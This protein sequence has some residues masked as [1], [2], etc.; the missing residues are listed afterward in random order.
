MSVNETLFASVVLELMR[1]AA[2]EL[3]EPVL[4]KLHEKYDMETNQTARKQFEAIFNNCKIACDRQVPVCQDNG[5]TQIFIDFGQQCKMEGNLEEAAK[6]AIAIATKAIPLR[7]NAIHPLSKKNP[8]TNV[9]QNIPTIYWKPIVGVDYMDVTV[10]PKGNGSEMR[11]THSWVLTSDDIGR[12]TVRAVLDSVSDMMGEPCPPIIIGVGLGGH[13]DS[14]AVLA[15]RALF[16]EPIGAPSSDPMAASLEKEILEA[17]NALKLGP[18]GFGGD[19]YAL[20]VHIEIS[21]AHTAIVPITVAVECWCHRYSKARIYS[22]GRVE[23]LTHPHG[24]LGTIPLDYEIPKVIGK[25]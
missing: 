20:A 6:Q 8:G 15:K 13:F 25:P 11:N 1:L 24:E 10:I 14:N 9:E 21:G 22:D 7:E 18:M 19:T 5:L 4:K 23:F 2:I 16:R 3:P 17:V 12:A